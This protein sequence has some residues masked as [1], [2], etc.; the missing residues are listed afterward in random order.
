MGSI[1]AK[2]GIPLS[3]YMDE[4]VFYLN[5]MIPRYLY[6]DGKRTEEIQ[7]Y[8]YTVTNIGSFEQVHIFVP[9]SKPV[10]EPDRLLELQEKGEKKF[11]EFEEALLRPYYNE[12]TRSLEDSIRAKSVRLVV[13]DSEVIYP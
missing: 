10:I 13:T 2:K 5:S 3:D 6:T 9:G 1:V 11:V 12:R 7:G 8:V 4:S